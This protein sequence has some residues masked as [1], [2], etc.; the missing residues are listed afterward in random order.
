MT[1]DKKTGEVEIFDPMEE[2]KNPRKKIVKS[3]DEIFQEKE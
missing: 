1:Y 2:K 3:V